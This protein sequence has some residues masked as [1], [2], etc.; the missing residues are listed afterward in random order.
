MYEAANDVQ[1]IGD[2]R[3][4]CM[5]NRYGKRRSQSPTVKRGVVLLNGV[6]AE[7][8]GSVEETAQNG[9]NPIQIAK[10]T[11]E[12]NFFSDGSGSHFCSLD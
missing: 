10:S 3:G 9:L 8:T 11:D 12:V 1:S 5:V 6:S 4:A 7:N 2:T